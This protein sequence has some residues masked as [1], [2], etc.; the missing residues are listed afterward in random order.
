MDSFAFLLVPDF[1][2]AL[3]LPGRGSS[4]RWD[5][6][7]ILWRNDE[8]PGDKVN[9]NCIDQPTISLQC[10]INQ[11]I[12]N[13][14]Y[15]IMRFRAVLGASTRLAFIPLT[16][17]HPS[18]NSKVTI[19]NIPSPENSIWACSW[20]IVDDLRSVG[21]SKYVYTWALP[22]SDVVLNILNPLSLLLLGCK[23]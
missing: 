8:E 23:I 13:T 6:T 1:P 17:P 16:S 10:H 19:F 14:Q 18:L 12:T 20:N 5:Q 15:I 3:W 4:S 11:Y 9:F 2:G 21:Y 7:K 22:C